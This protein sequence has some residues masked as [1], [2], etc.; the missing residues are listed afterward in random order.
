MKLYT[1]VL[2]LFGTSFSTPSN[3]TEKP[4]AG[5]LLA[6][7]TYKLEFRDGSLWADQGTY[8]SEASAMSALDSYSR[9]RPS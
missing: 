4:S 5:S 8:S 7:T 6:S 1:L 2:C 3:H 9:S